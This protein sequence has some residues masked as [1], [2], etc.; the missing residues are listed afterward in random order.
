MQDELV[1]ALFSFTAKR[2]NDN[3]LSNIIEESGKSADKVATPTCKK[4]SSAQ[5]GYQRRLFPKLHGK[6]LQVEGVV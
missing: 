5:V 4:C 2:S 1:A 6:V 3:C